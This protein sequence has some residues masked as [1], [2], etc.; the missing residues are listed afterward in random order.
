MRAGIVW[1]TVHLLAAAL[2]GIVLHVVIFE[3]GLAP[4]LQATVV[5]LGSKR[6]PS[7][8]SKPIQISACCAET[9]RINHRKPI[10]QIK[11]TD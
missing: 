5:A 7:Q 4:T 6:H 2:L 10:L 11:D 1:V 9:F 8:S 3:K